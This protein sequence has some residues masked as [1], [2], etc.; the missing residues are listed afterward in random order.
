[1]TEKIKGITLEIGGDTTGLDKALKGVNKESADLQSELKKVDRLLKLDPTN[2]ELL[3]QKQA[4]LSKSIETTSGK[5]E[6]LKTAEKQVQDQFKEGK[7]SEEQYRALQREIVN[8]EQELK[9][10][11]KQAN[12]TGKSF[13]WLGEKS[14]KMNKI[15]TGAAVGLAGVGAGLVGA[16]VNAG[17]AADDINTLSKQT[18]LS[19]EQI[20]KFQYA[21]DIIDVS[22]DTLTGSMA[23]LTKNMATAQ[24]GSGDAAKAFET[25]GVKITNQDGSLRN[26]QDVFNET[27]KKLGE[28]KNETQ[29]DAYAMQIFGKSAQDLNP[30]ILGGADALEELGKQAED[31]GLIM[32][33]DA[34]DGANAFNDGLDILKAQGTAAIG[35]IGGE[36]AE[37]LM[38]ALGKI[39]DAVSKII[40]WVLNNK[41]A[42][43]L[44]ITVVTAAVAG[45]M[46]VLAVQKIIAFAKALEGVTV[47]QKLL[48]L[49]MS[50]NP[51]GL[52]IAA[53]AALVA[54]FIYLWNNCDEFR[55]FWIS[56][57]DSI[58]NIFNASVDWMKT[59][60]TKTIPEFFSG[61]NQWLTNIFAIDWTKNFG[62]FGN[63]INAFF[64]DVSNIWNAIKSIFTGIIDFIKNVFTGNWQGAWEA[65]KDIFK[66]VF[67]MLLG[68]AKAPLNGIIAL[69]N[70]TID[71]INM[72]IK[73]LN[74]I[75][76]DIPDWIPGIGGNEFGIHIPLVGKIP[77]LAN[78]GTLSAGS[79]IVG[80]AGPELL[81]MIGGRAV[82][83]PLTNSQKSG[84]G[85]NVNMNCVFNGYKHS[86]GVLA[87]RDLM[88]TID[89][90]LGRAF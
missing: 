18:G 70:G 57:W 43:V 40:D 3:A 60:F 71:G 55:N 15:M 30:L 85:I 26:N 34:L 41:D 9:R 11:E 35:K 54:A 51:I 76:F 44:A 66:G 79:A 67:D 33:Q 82:V 61:L 73:G 87:S 84:G 78:G 77:M 90:Q 83:Q 23:K 4:L 5:L 50:M 48:N 31:A 19:T 74:K 21:T 64:Q 88:R 22:M 37:T 29:R 62:A 58:V 52:I 16:A 10:L 65:V 56:L 38:P 6:T 45:F 17:K 32:S 12:G 1:M 53:I 8:A 68:I 13:D 42:V 47:A 80:E 72:L 20:Q 24:K 59:T 27:I 7:I 25:L 46:A 86:D 28:M 75:N 2:T 36:I 89:R 81:S 49:V 39:L 69:L 14:E 63:V